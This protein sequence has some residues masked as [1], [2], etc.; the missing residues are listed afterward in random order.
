MY[1]HAKHTR[2]F[3]ELLHQMREASTL[4]KQDLSGDKSKFFALSQQTRIR[5]FRGC[6]FFI[7]IIFGNLTIY[8]K[9][10]D[11]NFRTHLFCCDLQNSQKKIE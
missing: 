7:Y 1:T 8:I 10:L 5:R 4:L 11:Y 9:M 6:Y 2:I 3:H